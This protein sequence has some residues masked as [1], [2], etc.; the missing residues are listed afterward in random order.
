MELDQALYE[1]LFYQ[2]YERGLRPVRLLGVGVRFMEPLIQ[3]T[4]LRLF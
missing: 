3:G 1:Q 4:Q 2:A